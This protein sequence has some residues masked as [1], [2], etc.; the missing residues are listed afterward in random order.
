MKSAE[1]PKI[2]LKICPQCQP[3]GRNDNACTQC[4]GAYSGIAHKGEFLYWGTSLTSEEIKFRHGMLKTGV[5]WNLILGIL[6]LV[7]VGYFAYT[8]VKPFGVG[9]GVSSSYFVLW[10]GI[11]IWLYLLMRVIRRTKSYVPIQYHKSWDQK[12]KQEVIPDNPWAKGA[13]SHIKNKKEISQSFSKE[14][15][16]VLE[17]AY[18]LAETI[19]SAE[20]DKYQILVALLGFPEIQGILTRLGVSL[21]TVKDFAG[22][23]AKPNT[24]GVK[25]PVYNTETVSLFYVAYLEAAKHHKTYVGLGELLW[26]VYASSREMQEFFYDLGI[27]IRQM[28]NVIAW[29]RVRD[30]LKQRWRMSRSAAKHRRKGGMDKAMTAVATPFLNALSQDLTVMAAYGHLEQLVGREAELQTVFRVLQGGKQSVLLVGE[31]GVGKEAIVEGLAL[32]MVRDDVPPVLQDKRL[33]RLSVAKLLAGATPAQAQ[34]RLLRVI[35]E[36][37]RAKN[38]ILFIADIENM[39]GVTTGGEGSLDVAEV[40]A[41]GLEKGGF[42]MF[43]T[44]TPESYRRFVS[45]TTTAQVFSKVDVEEM[46]VDQAIQVLEAKAGRTEYE[47]KV[48]FS[49]NAVEQ[50]AM[51][52]G[53]YIQSDRLPRKAMQVMKEAAELASNERGKDTL[54]TQHDVSKI[55]SEKSKIP[56]TAVGEDE[57]ERLLRLEKAL[58]KRIVGQNEAVEVVSQALRRARAQLASGK[59][60][61]ANFLF[62]GPTG[63]GKTELAKTV[64]SVY[65]GGEQQMIRF[66]MSEF[67]DDTSFVRL[68]G[69]PNKKG[70]GILTEAIR[71]KPF[72]VLLLDELEKANPKVL[73]LFLQLM[74]DGRITDSTGKTID[75]TNIMLVA[76]SNAGTQYVSEQLKAGKSYEALQDELMRGKLSEWFRPE[77]LN[78]FDAI[79]LFEALTQ[80]NIREI[81]KLML[82]KV[83]KKLDDQG[84]LLEVDDAVIE[85]LAK[86]GFDPQFGARP[87]RRTIQDKVENS[88]AE[89]ILGKKVR[90]GDV[91]HFTSTGVNVKTK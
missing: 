37:R 69:Q 31:S 3:A 12:T 62:L 43:A 17:N 67:Q 32:R 36:V 66:D 20:V 74:D 59:R 24:S 9:V 72:A 86:A 11:L 58:H 63:V 75:C 28:K 33:V 73:N 83:E 7:C 84:I 70:S 13:F 10:L 1:L 76:T 90:R 39:I 40:L 85:D 77:F 8:F 78:R 49:Y 5:I 57:S 91:I 89:L 54:V 53:K 50:A 68:I 23:F 64:S 71:E 29:V 87:M 52:S 4:R 38:I 6:G 79:V 26:G 42:L 47:K 27:D 2:D 41:R 61:I 19:K 21:H 44:T 82:K 18:F 65:F 48:W 25:H 30:M 22:K 45:N 80:E 35:A 81:A 60:T 14:S 46:S 34:E 15:V 16:L 55:V 88:I 51:L 56:V